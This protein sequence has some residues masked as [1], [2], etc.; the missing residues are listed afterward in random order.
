MSTDTATDRHTDLVLEVAPPEV[1]HLKNRGTIL[2]QIKYFFIFEGNILEKFL[3]Q[4][5]NPSLSNCLAFKQTKIKCQD[6]IKYINLN[7]FGLQQYNPE[8]L[9]A[10]PS[11]L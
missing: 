1:G 4:L 6:P 10:D 5:L 7:F 2:Q 3:P 11:D 8:N 9:E